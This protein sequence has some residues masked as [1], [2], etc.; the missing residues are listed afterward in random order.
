MSGLAKLSFGWKNTYVH[1]YS[2]FPYNF[3]KKYKEEVALHLY[4]ILNP[5]LF[6]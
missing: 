1:M 2:G 3:S 4:I 5:L 6:H